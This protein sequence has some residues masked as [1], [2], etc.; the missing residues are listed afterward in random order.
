[1]G[2]ND[3]CL[4]G[5]CGKQFS[6]SSNLK[7]HEIAAHI[8]NAKGSPYVGH[9]RARVTKENGFLNEKEKKEKNRELKAAEQSSNENP[10]TFC[11][12]HCNLECELV[13]D[14]NQH[15]LNC[16]ETSIKLQDID[17]TVVFSCNKCELICNSAHVL[18]CHLR[19]DHGLVKSG[20]CSICGAIFTSKWYEKIHIGTLSHRFRSVLSSTNAMWTVIDNI[21]KPGCHRQLQSDICR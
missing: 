12:E 20:V 14:L 17:K 11:C 3:E 7:K 15:V 6:N 16:F 5:T 9:K 19:L 1:M 8:N 2:E 4:C 10:N 13:S 18:K 21:L